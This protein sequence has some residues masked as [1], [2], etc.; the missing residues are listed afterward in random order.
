MLQH[1]AV[2][3]GRHNV[4]WCTYQLHR[5]VVNY[6]TAPFMARNAAST[7]RRCADKQKE[8]NARCFGDWNSVGCCF[9][10]MLQIPITASIRTLPTPH[11]ASP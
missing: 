11:S 5:Y 3:K 4:C 7:V 2:G 6:I 1:R 8:G 10:T 9:E